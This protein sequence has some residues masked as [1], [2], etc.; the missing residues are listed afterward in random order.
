[1][2]ILEFSEETRDG[3]AQ[4]MKFLNETIARETRIKEELL[5]HIRMLAKRA[6]W[7]EEEVEIRS[8]EGRDLFIELTE[9]D[10]GYEAILHLSVNSQNLYRFPVKL[11]MFS[12]VNL[13]DRLA[14]YSH[15]VNNVA[16]L[17][18]MINTEYAG[19]HMDFTIT[20]DAS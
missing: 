19:K 9:E 17:A 14:D 13:S 12:H 18:D 8:Y 16:V 20:W 5:P 2:S 6:G 7:A 15:F 10:T 1:M 3:I 4:A 11:A